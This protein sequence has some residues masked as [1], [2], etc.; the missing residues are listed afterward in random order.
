[1]VCFGPQIWPP[2]PCP[3]IA[4]LTNGFATRTLGR[5]LISDLPFHGTW[6][7]DVGSSVTFTATGRAPAGVTDP[8]STNNSESQTVRDRGP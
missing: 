4:Q 1:M 8:D 2:P 6:N 5:E 7:A 3:T